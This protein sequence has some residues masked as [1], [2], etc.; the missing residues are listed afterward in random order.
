MVLEPDTCR[1]GRNILSLIVGAKERE[2]V[3]LWMLQYLPDILML[4][5]GYEAIGVA[6]GNR[7]IGGCLY[8]N[9]IPTPGGGDIQVWAVGEPGWLNRRMIR[10]LLGYPFLQLNCHR[11]TALT[12]KGNKPSRRLLE[13]VGFRLEGIARRGLTARK[14]ACI[15]SLLKAEC[16]W[17]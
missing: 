13:G 10:A 15:Y 6:R 5:G 4:P 14:D 3:G 12:G 1:E 7:I 11:M 9:Y 17:V 8:T 16:G 2:K